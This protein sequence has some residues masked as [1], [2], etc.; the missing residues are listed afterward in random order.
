MW[1]PV[2]LKEIIKTHP[3]KTKWL[4]STIMTIQTSD[5]TFQAPSK[6]QKTWASGFNLK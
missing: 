3:S 5:R 4:L 6:I 2:A 1:C